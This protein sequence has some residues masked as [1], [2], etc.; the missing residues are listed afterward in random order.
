MN[1]DTNQS[2]DPFSSPFSSSTI[3]S[4]SPIITI[5]PSEL[6][7]QL[8]QLLS[9]FEKTS[10]QAFS[11][12]SQQE[13]NVATEALT[14]FSSSISSIPH[15]RLLLDHSKEPYALLLAA[16]AMKTLCTT[17]WNNFTVPQT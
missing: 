8:Q 7:P 3:D 14:N 9:L 17:F 6:T 13:R 4:S 10:I 1:E 5:S 11:S 15:C 12:P 16:K 2:T